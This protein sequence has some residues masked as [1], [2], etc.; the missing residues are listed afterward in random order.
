M[1]FWSQITDVLSS[2][3]FRIGAGAAG[4]ASGAGA[5]DS[6]GDWGTALQ[7]LSSV[8][9][10]ASG[11]AS[12]FGPGHSDLDKATGALQIGLGGYNAGQAFGA[13]GNF[14]DVWNQLSGSGG[15]SPGSAVPGLTD[16]GNGA[17]SGYP[18]YDESVTRTPLAPFAG[19]PTDPATQSPF[20]GRAYPVSTV[21]ADTP[22]YRGELS[23]AT[24]DLGT[25]ARAQLTPGD[26]PDAWAPVPP[27][28]M[29]G[30][31]PQPPVPPLDTPA[32]TPAPGSLDTTAQPGP[33]HPV[34]HATV[35]PTTPTAPTA[36]AGTPPAA[37]APS[38]DIGSMQSRAGGGTRV[39]GNW[40][41]RAWTSLADA[42]AA[43]PVSA[44]MQAVQIG[45][46]LVPLFGASRADIAAQT[47]RDLQ[48][49]QPT[50]GT[51][52]DGA[53]FRRLFGERAT[54]A[55]NEQYATT[56]SGLE[57]KFA[58][59]GMLR[60]T[61]YTNALA[62][63]DKAKADNIANIETNAYSA[64]NQALAEWNRTAAVTNQ[65]AAQQAANLTA[66]GNYVNQL[67][68]QMDFSNMTRV[69]ANSPF[70]QQLAANQAR[71]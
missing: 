46:M 53:E 60:S 69:L 37:A 20:N 15:T 7:G 34:P 16:R 9:N 35:A 26:F 33:V 52:P 11:A 6:L 55:I 2:P 39:D 27:P 64:W 13:V 29:P 62:A 50:P 40:F 28:S 54:R 24:T 30:G 71:T 56:A 58:A 36:P 5:F 61:V 21:S 63:L 48:A 1:S 65:T 38:V 47:L 14:G 18:G 45:S 70:S 51:P 59:R 57:A 22:G 68:P 31:G 12:T 32:A 67:V 8:A 42:A 4:L 19:Q 44:A 3:A 43:N 25:G 23:D 49:Q 10:V 41:D 66:V 17:I